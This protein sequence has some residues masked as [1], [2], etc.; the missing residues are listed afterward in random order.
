MNVL[1]FE[2][3]GDGPTRRTKD[4]RSFRTLG[5]PSQSVVSV[6]INGEEEAPSSQDSKKKA[7]RVH[8]RTD[9]KSY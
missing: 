9:I 4:G 7:R 3:D 2:D 6:L 5:G 1:E 8:Q